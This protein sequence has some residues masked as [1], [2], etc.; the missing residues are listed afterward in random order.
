M[1]QFRGLLLI[2]I[3]NYCLRL[4]NASDVELPIIINKH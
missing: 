3:N 1:P 4:S 2:I